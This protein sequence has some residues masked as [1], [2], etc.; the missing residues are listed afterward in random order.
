[1]VGKGEEAGEGVEW[2]FGISRCKL[3]YPGWTKNK[4]ALQS[5]GNCIQ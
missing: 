3:V 5:I 4:V 2:D 1:M